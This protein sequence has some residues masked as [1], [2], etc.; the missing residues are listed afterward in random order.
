MKRE[1]GKTENQM[2]LD[3]LTQI[4]GS[5][6]VAERRLSEIR[7]AGERIFTL[8]RCFNLREG[9][10][11]EDLDVLPS[12]MFEPSPTLQAGKIT[13]TREKLKGML[14]EY[15]ELRGWDNKGVPEPKRLKALGLGF[16]IAEKHTGK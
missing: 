5:K 15:Y 9:L 13:L 7:K 2:I 14:T 8:E 11:P 16:L 4:F 10:S 3:F 12:R 6:K 1:K